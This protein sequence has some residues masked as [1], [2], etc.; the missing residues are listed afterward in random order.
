MATART[1]VTM[2]EWLA[3]TDRRNL[4][5]GEWSREAARAQ[6]RE[7]L[8]ELSGRVCVLLGQEVASC[9]PSLGRMCR[10]A[11]PMGTPPRAAPP[12]IHIPH[13]SG[14]CR[15]YNDPSDLAAAEILLGDL[16]T[17]CRE[18]RAA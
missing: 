4:C 5:V 17:E 11:V 9:F 1:G 8:P 3:M 15:W 18:R 6:A 13:P 7:W 2:E 16:V 10:W 14:L 12:W